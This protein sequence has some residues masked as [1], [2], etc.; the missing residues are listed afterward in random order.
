MDQTVEKVYGSN[1]PKPDKKK[2][3]TMTEDK[4]KNI[5]RNQD[6]E[7]WKKEMNDKSTLIIRLYKVQ[8]LKFLK[9][10]GMTTLNH[11]GY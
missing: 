8:F 5:I 10:H 1:K 11:H 4:L 2:I 6:T 3:K 9:H 7:A